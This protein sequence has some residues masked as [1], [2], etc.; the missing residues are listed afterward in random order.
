MVIFCVVKVCRA[1]DLGCDLSIARLGQACLI[2]FACLKCRLV[3]EVVKAKYS[4]AVLAANVVALAHP[5]SRVVGFPENLEQLLIDAIVISI[6]VAVIDDQHAFGV[7]GIAGADCLIS[8][9]FGAAAGITY[10]GQINICLLPEATL[11]SPEASECENRLSGVGREG[12]MQ[13]TSFNK[14]IA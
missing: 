9:S 14:M 8:G 3:L 2:G 12:G 4:R 11:C 1:D 10:C 6:L 7:A 13:G 5:L